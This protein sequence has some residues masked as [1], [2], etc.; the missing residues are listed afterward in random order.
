M[1]AE[2]RCTC[3]P[4]QTVLRAASEPRQD[5]HP[6]GESNPL[7]SPGG[8]LGLCE[9]SSSEAHTEVPIGPPRDWANLANLI[10]G[11]CCAWRKGSGANRRAGTTGTTT[12]EREQSIGKRAVS[13][14][15]CG[16]WVLAAGGRWC[17]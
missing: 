5:F 2:N 3:I 4:L 1:L 13:R 11:C 8:I 14:K 17:M 9:G 16:D 12:C 10:S 15:S 6:N 7:D